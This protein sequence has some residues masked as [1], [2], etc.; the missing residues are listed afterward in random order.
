MPLTD[1]AVGQARRKRLHPQRRRWPSPVRC[2]QR[3]QRV[4]TFRSPLHSKPARISLGTYPET[5][6]KDARERRDK[7]R[8]LV[9]EGIGPRLQRRKD[10][11]TAGLG[12]ANAFE[13]VANR[14]Y[15][16][17]APRLTD[18]RKGSAAQS[19][20]YLE[21]G[22]APTLGKV[23]IAIAHIARTDVLGAVCRVEARKALNVAE[24]CRTW[25]N[26]IFRFVIAEGLLEVNP[27]ADLDIVAA[28]QPPVK[29]NPILRR[30]EL[31]AF[32]AHLRVSQVWK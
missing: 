6:L 31:P 27:A 11:Q 2:H 25:L 24:K 20:R 23:P 32:L 3:Q 12:A 22:L 4:G 17:K 14:W 16:F 29:H 1:T 9:A 30:E 7:A 19:K 18:R 15:D 13:A 21:K 8:E 26:Q 10:Q 5:S 28:A